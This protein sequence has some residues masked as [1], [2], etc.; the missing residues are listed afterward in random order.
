MMVIYTKDDCPA[1]IQAKAQM[2]QAGQE[3]REMKI[4]TDISREEFMTKFPQIRSVP[5]VVIELNPPKVKYI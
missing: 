3:Y 2:D 5:Y 4:G 1:C